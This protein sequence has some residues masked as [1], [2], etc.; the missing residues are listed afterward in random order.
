M[1]WVL[2]VTNVAPDEKLFHEN[3]LVKVIKDLRTH[4]APDMTGL[5]P[6]HIKCIFRGRRETGSPEART[7]ILLNRLIHETLEDPSMMGPTDFWENFAGGKLSVIPQENK[8]RPVGQKN[9]LYKIMTSIL[10]RTNDKALVRLAGPAHLAGKPSGVLAAAIMAQMELD[11]AQFVVEDDPEDIRCVLTTDARAAFQS[12]SR[13]NCYKVLCTDD[14]LK[15]RFAPFFAHAHKGSQRIVWPATLRPSSGFTQGDINSSKLFTCNTASLVQGLQD[16]GGEDATVVAI[17]DDITVMGSLA[18][19]ISVEKSRD[20]LQKPANY[21]VNPLKQY[22]YTMNE[23]HV[24]QIQSALPEHSVIYIGSEQGFCLSGIPLGG[25]QFILSKL[26]NN[27]DKTKEVIANIC[28][29]KNTQE[30]LILLLQCIPGRIQHL[31][32]AVPIYLSRDFARQHDEAISEAVAATLD[33]GVL[34]DRDKLLM[35]RKI[36]KH[37]LGLRSMEKKLEFLFISGFIRSIKSVKNTFPNINK[38]LQYTIQGESGLGRQLADALSTL[39]E[40]RNQKLRLLLPDTIEHALSDSFEWHHDEIQREL[41]NLVVEAHDAL[42]DLS[43]I[44]DQQDKATL[45]STDTSIFQLIPRSKILQIPNEDLIYLAKQLFGKAQRRYICKFCPN[46]AQSTG[47][48]C[49]AR[50]DS[51][52]LHLRTCKINNVHHQKHEALRFWFK[53]FV[54]QAHI[55]T[56]PAPP[57]SEVSQRNPTKQ[58]AGDLMLVDVSLRQAE[59]DGKCGVLDFSIITPAAESYCA[60]AAKQPLHAAKIR[61]DAKILKYLQAYKNLDDIHFEPFVV[62]SGGQLGERAQEIFKKICNLITQTTGQSGSSIAYFW[63]SRLL[64]T[65]AKITYSN[66]LRWATAHNK[67]KDPDSTPTDLTDC[68]DDDTHEIRRMMHSSGVE[69]RTRGGAELTDEDW[70][71]P[72][73]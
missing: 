34:T 19:L 17:V 4:A 57:I 30:K 43:R 9:I 26:Q 40:F 22:V 5:R 10:G 8:A 68:Y 18:A 65:L 27:L 46:V 50:L 38:A 20:S 14:T 64:V 66:A 3:L 61:E 72:I 67:S 51:R 49:G 6:S 62:E 47:N 31:L 41:D 63:K 24:T 28:K 25:D 16:A 32:A 54:K 7:R 58:L 71:I 2:H 55:K 11:Y 33:L 52:D 12:A 73:I 59:R 56:A 60:G 29:L 37:G 48:I 13:R 21:L 45:L 53:D 15:E 36:S 69:M 23:Q 35:Q 44:P 42:Y 1:T 39:H 70:P